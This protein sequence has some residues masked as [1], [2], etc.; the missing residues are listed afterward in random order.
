MFL[1]ECKPDAVLVES[2]ILTSRKNI[3][4]AGNKSE[5]LK[6]LTERYS[7]SEGV[8][9]EDPWSIQ[10]PHMQKFEEK[11]N[12]TSYGLKMLHQTSKNNTLIVLCPRL[13]DWIL[14]AAQEAN[15]D[16]QKYNLP[17]DPA[18][19]HQQINIQID[20]FQKLVEKL[21]TKSNRL[22]K[23]AIGLRVEFG[24]YPNIKILQFA[25]PIN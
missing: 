16:P 25:R 19:L 23:L 15:V 6:K 24:S 4:H 17:N 12:L 22:N 20:K 11:Q 7:D 10:P 2:L 5:L 18:K 9:D 14:E 13:E 3:Q 8:I 21:K 1:V